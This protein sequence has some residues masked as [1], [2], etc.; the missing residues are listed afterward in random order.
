MGK[1]IVNCVVLFASLSIT[2]CMDGPFYTLKRA[3][4]FYMSQ[5][6]KDS[7]RGETFDARIQEIRSLEGRIAK[8]GPTEQEQWALR[9]EEIVKNDPS[10]EMRR[11]AVRSAAKIVSPTTTRILNM[12]SGDDVEKV[13]MATC[14]AWA[15]RNDAA[16]KDMLLSLAQQDSSSSVRQAAITALKGFNDP[17]VIRSMASLLDDKSPAVQ[18]NAT[19]TLAALTGQKHGG[20]VSAWKSYMNRALPANPNPG[21]ESQPG[22]D[23]PVRMAGGENELPDFLNR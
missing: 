8:L 12:T 3:N 21:V 13:R 17:E 20:D 4:P 14:E 15:S 2:G 22:F 16:A 5:W 11:Q 18:Y 23:L 1:W 19:Q 10:P 7:K 6:H 9:L